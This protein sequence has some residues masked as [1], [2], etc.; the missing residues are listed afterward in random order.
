MRTTP[1]Q[2][3]S[4]PPLRWHFGSACLDEASLEFTQHG[5]PVE[6]ERRPLELLALLL[7]HAGE[8]VTKA[9]IFSA[10]WTGREVSDAS[11]TKCVARLRRALND[12]DHTVVHTVHG[13]GYRFVAAVTAE[14]CTAPRQ[15][16]PLALQAGDVIPARP[17]WTLVRLLGV[18]TAG[19]T[20]LCQDTLTQERRAVKFARN[21]AGAAA[22]RREVTLGRLLHEALGQRDD[23]ISVLD[24]N[25][26][27]QPYFIATAWRELG[28]FG[29]WTAA[30]GGVG[31]LDLALRI[32]LVA[33]VAEALAA[34]HAA[35]VLHADVKPANIL[36]RA[37]P[38]GPAIV[39]ADFGNSCAADAA[40]PDAFGASDRDAT[41]TT[42]AR[43][44]QAPELGPGSSPTV[45]ADI[46]ALGVILFQ[47][48]A[49]DL[50][51]PLAPGW[52]EHVADPLLREDI[53]LAASGYPERR[54]ASAAELATRLR[55][56]G[57]RRQD[58]SNAAARALEAAQLR[59]SLERARAR[60]GPMRALACALTLGMAATTCLTLRAE[61]ADRLAEAEASSARA[62]TS[63]LT[64]DL[65]SA[66]NPVLGANPNVPVKTV[67]AAATVDLDHRFASGALNRATVEAAIGGAYAGL[68]D[69]EHA[70]PLL[71]AA[72][73][74]LRRNLG[75]AA[76]QALAV[77]LVVTDLAERMADL[78]TM[79]EQGRAILAAH[80]NDADTELRARFA[81]F[82]AGCLDDDTD[83][84]CVA[85]LRPFLAEVQRRTGADSLL[86]LRTQDLLAYQL[87][88]GQHVDEAVPLARRTVAQAQAAYGPDSLH[89]QERRFFLAVVLE[90]AGQRD[91]AIATLIDVRRRLL[92]MSG[93][94][95][96]L[97]NRVACQLGRTY[98]AAR[99]YDE[100]LPLLRASL[101]FTE[102]THGD[103]YEFT[104]HGMI[105]LAKA[106]SDSG[107]S[108][109]AIPLGER[110]FELQRAAYGP[111]NE[112]T[113]WIQSYL[114]GEYQG[115]GDLARA[116]AILGDI[117]ARSHRVF[118]HGEWNTGH[119]EML[120]G[121][122]LAAEGKLS[123]ARSVLSDSFTVLSAALGPDNARTR[124]VQARLASLK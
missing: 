104:R 31:R 103:N 68:A 82:Y 106:L 56:L 51:H 69:P 78:P 30:Q 36:M 81:L 83:S 57:E 54:L 107:H 27:E 85:K 26:E 124:D 34:A 53:A 44:Y 71:H 74:A 116:E 1:V 23:L 62:V 70:L 22:L 33:Q 111:D 114:A 9:E 100:A 90:Q 76:P 119:F 47:V 20:W 43:L 87:A 72:L 58:R 108:S 122:V 10:V 66:A 38:L 120:L 88:E 52:E 98:A 105:V 40:H 67:L 42:G 2:A 15:P 21:A 77:R 80:P 101:A 92:A 63:F 14:A 89:A 91:E 45:Q 11:L 123:G 13:Y 113:L 118:T 75:D 32:D 37:G 99:R 4:R 25:L 61:R 50:R 3:A 60:R 96:E 84:A 94:Q 7:A 16:A 28:N 73:S 95:T 8:V 117:V 65:F 55:R 49:G 18:G 39:L 6:L 79:R 35:G 97:S 59:Q 121:G 41:S 64:D 12:V 29:Q 48:A 112:D 24:W 5:Q 17:G 46:Y 93:T 86:T 110:A 19:D 102:R 115:A 109:E